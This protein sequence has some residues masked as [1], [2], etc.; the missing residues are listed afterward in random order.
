MN[1]YKERLEN[2]LEIPTAALVD[3]VKETEDDE[4][5]TRL[6]S[7]AALTSLGARKRRRFGHAL[8]AAN[9]ASIVIPAEFRLKNGKP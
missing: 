2:D 3:E 9:A 5:F 7:F 6:P 8:N 4:M 1:N